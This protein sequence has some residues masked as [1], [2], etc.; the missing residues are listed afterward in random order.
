MVWQNCQCSIGY[1]LLKQT[2]YM[3]KRFHFLNHQ[4][5]DGHLHLLA[6]GC[7]YHCP[8]RIQ[9]LQRGPLLQLPKRESDHPTNEERIAHSQ[10]MHCG[11]TKF[12]QDWLIFSISTICMCSLVLECRV[13]KEDN[14]NCC[15][16]WTTI[17]S[18]II[19]I[20]N[21][22]QIYRWT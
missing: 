8:A 20:L 4:A 19:Y 1:R 6:Q 21:T 2:I 15:H 17:M 13:A 9:L 7:C 12:G 16:A 10:H 22:V 5:I 18:S 14:L 11:A 3:A